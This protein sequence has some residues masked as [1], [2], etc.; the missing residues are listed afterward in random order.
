M[1]TYK[2][3]GGLVTRVACPKCERREDEVLS[4]AFI[5]D[6]CLGTGEADGSGECPACEGFGFIPCPTCG[7]RTYVSLEQAEEIKRGVL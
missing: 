1:K 5:C 3:F 7:G 6:S 2:T 4:G